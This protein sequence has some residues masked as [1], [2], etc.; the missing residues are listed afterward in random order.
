M[1]HTDAPVVTVTTTIID[2]TVVRWYR[3]VGQAENR[4][5]VLSASRRGV[6]VHAEYL[7]DLPPAWIDAAKAAHKRL[8][9]SPDA[10]VNDLA[11]HRQRMVH[12]T[13]SGPLEPIS[14]E[15]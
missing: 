5:P 2:G 6:R 12:G 13:R 3:T 9:G 14:K 8:S 7:T 4:R 15:G 11:T 10:D 1:T